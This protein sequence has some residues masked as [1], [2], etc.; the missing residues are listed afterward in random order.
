MEDSGGQQSE[1]EVEGNRDAEKA[2]T[3]RGK[4]VASGDAGE[5]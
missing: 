4:A 3:G 1:E 2:D 5:R